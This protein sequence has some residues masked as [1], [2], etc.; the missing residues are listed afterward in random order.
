MPLK[1]EGDVKWKR[2]VC[3]WGRD[4]VTQWHH[5]IE[6]AFDKEPEKL[7]GWYY[8]YNVQNFRLRGKCGK[9]N[10]YEGPKIV[11]YT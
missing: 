11:W 9:N 6:K 8:V 1:N 2:F 3:Q 10:N 7:D 5:W 4:N